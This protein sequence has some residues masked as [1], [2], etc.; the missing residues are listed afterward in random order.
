MINPLTHNHLL[1]AVQDVSTFETLVEAVRE[2]E[3]AVF[4]LAAGP[5]CDEEHQQDLE[6]AEDRHV[7]L[8]IALKAAMVLRAC[9]FVNDTQ[10]HALSNALSTR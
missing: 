5:I 7:S 1:A 10:A 6:D 8:S 3:A 2:A 4:D 9:G